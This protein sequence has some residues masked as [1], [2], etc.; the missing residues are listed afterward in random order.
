MSA[1]DELMESEAD[2][3]LAEAPA[4]ETPEVTVFA[5]ARVMLPER[6]LR[7]A[8]T[9]EDGVIAD[10]R[11]GA[12]VPSLRGATVVD[13]DG[14]I[15][16]PG[17]VELHTDNIEKHMLPRPGAMWPPLA[18]A[19]A[20]DMQIAAAGITTV[21][22]SVA[23]GAFDEGNLR[24][25]A[26]EAICG[27]L[28]QGE[29]AGLFKARHLLHLRCEVGFPGMEELLPPLI[30]RPLVGLIS[31]MDHTPGQRQ[32][33]DESKY[34]EY[35]QGKHGFTNAEMAEWMAERKRDQKRYSEPNRAY[36]VR[37]AQAH[38]HAIASHD[39]A[40]EAHVGEAV[41]DRM[42]IAE[43]PTTVE[44][45]S[46]SHNAGLAVLMGAPNIVRGGSHSGNVAAVDLAR[47]GLLDIV[48][49]DYAPAALIH[50]VFLLE[51]QVA[52]MD[53]A[54]AVATVTATPAR[55]AGL[56]DRGRM[57]PGLIADLLR[58]HDHDH[59]PVLRGVWRDGRRIA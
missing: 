48:S 32:F 39:D 3:D 23:V 53:M 54:A 22:D 8:V 4:D 28:E 40:T 51:E 55:A 30:G 35:Y 59:H 41:R 46:A 18:A 12:G 58:V 33:R 6:E 52:E 37:E 31:V 17:M 9:V 27:A 38:G 26:L 43:F 24:L 29:H 21:Y 47:L 13:C 44:A 50:A 11:A 45:A 2:L 56:T 14:D 16:M 42:T 57:E 5:N 10:I 25:Q 15:L 1:M 49:S 34:V 19:V 20:H 36:V 7:G